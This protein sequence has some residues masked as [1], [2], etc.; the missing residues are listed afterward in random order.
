MWNPIRTIMTKLGIKR[1][2]AEPMTDQG[3]I[4]KTFSRIA[5]GSIRLPGPEVEVHELQT[6]NPL[7]R[8]FVIVVP[9]GADVPR[10]WRMIPKVGSEHPNPPTPH[11]PGGMRHWKC[12]VASVEAVE[13]G[14]ENT[15]IVFVSYQ[16]RRTDTAA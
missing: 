8:K 6:D 14:E 4:I 12:L 2:K 1:A 15:T 16:W 3:M 11:M 10:D 5:D 13:G 7:F 9:Q